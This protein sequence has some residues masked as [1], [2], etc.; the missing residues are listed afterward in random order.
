[1]FLDRELEREAEMKLSEETNQEWERRKAFLMGKRFNGVPMCNIKSH[2]ATIDSSVLY[3][4]MREICPEFDVSREDFIG[5]NRETYWKSIFDFKRLKVSKQKVFTGLIETDGVATCVLY[6]RLKKDR[7]VPPSAAPVTR[8]AENKEEDSVMQEVEDTEFVVD[9]TKDE[10]NKEEHPATQEVEDND[11]VVDVAKDED[12]K[13][14]DPSAQEVENNDFMVDAAKHG[15]NKEAGPATQEVQENDLVVGLDPGSTNILAIAAP[16]C[17]ED[18]TDGKLRQKDMRV[19]KLSNARY[20]RESGIINARKKIETWN[21]GIKEH[22]KAMSE[23]TSRGADFR[24]FRKFMEVRVAHWE[25][26]WEEYTKP[27]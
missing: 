17:A 25:A 16:K 20:Y 14:A 4:I 27:V 23:V 26:L 8:D 18:G 12:E 6:R 9:V 10:E 13:K 11:L 3:G 15:E 21:S 22:L 5:E 7:P 1:V 19:F 2:F 24:A